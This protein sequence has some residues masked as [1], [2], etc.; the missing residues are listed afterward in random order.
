MSDSDHTRVSNFEVLDQ[1]G[2]LTTLTD[3][4]FYLRRLVRVASVNEVRAADFHPGGFDHHTS[5]LFN[6]NETALNDLI[7]YQCDVLEKV[8]TLPD[9]IGFHSP[10]W[11]ILQKAII[12]MSREFKIHLQPS[13]EHIPLVVSRLVDL[14]M[15]D[16]FLQQSIVC[17]KCK[18]IFQSQEPKLD[19]AIIIVYLALLE[20]R[21]EARIMCRQ[22][23]TKLKAGLAEYEYCSNG[24]VPIYNY[25]VSDLISLIQIG[26]DTKFHLAK[27][28]G[29][30]KF[31]RLFPAKFHHAL[32]MDEKPEYYLGKDF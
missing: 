5:N 21:Q 8:W 7:D 13:E 25:P 1:W 2:D 32:L 30:K 27:I 28:L 3:R 19:R 4:R 10:E 29:D 18:V 11:Q 12:P 20:K 14:I 9:N 26:T 24:S 31:N 22:V 6:V 15:A 23:L 17:F 16:R